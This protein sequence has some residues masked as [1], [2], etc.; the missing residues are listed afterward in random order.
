MDVT[1]NGHSRRFRT[2]TFDSE[3]NSILLIEQ[4]L[5]PHQFKVIASADYL[6]TSKAI[7][8]MVVRGAGAIGATAAYGLAQGSRQ[9][10]GRSLALF[11]RH[12]EKVFTT[13][14][15]ARPT[16]VDPV[17]AMLRVKSQMAAGQSVAERQALALAAAEEFANANAVSMESGSSDPA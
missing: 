16:A 6:S 8:D 9:F 5:L 12:V 15:S 7:Q 17:N 2:V 10:A 11:N 13:I 4:R 1:V 3:T 14:Q